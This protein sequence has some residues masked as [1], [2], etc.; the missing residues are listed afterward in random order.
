VGTY[1]TFFVATDADLD[2]LFPGWKPARP[3]KVSVDNVNPFTKQVVRSKEWIGTEPPQRL[4]TP[5]LYEDTWG[6]PMEPVLEP[7]GEF[8]D[9]LRSIEEAA[10]P[11]LRAL[12]HF[13]GKNLTLLYTFDSLATALTGVQGEVPPAR[14]GHAEDDD[15]PCV[16][17]L[18]DA[19]LAR[20]AELGDDALDPLFLAW[21]EIDPLGCDI[22]P[23]AE[24]VEVYV[25][26][27]LAP[28]RALARLAL[29]RSASLCAYAA[30]HC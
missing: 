10:A 25:R 14:V 12:P 4:G 30:L 21:R 27:A 24:D 7:S 29:A 18:P 11:G 16:E 8:A 17:R 1:H 15:M 19:A 23:S 28:L 22:E 3:E 26:Y 5:N 9:S 20:L 2:G 13:R 6:P